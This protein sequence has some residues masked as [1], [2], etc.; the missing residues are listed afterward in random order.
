[1][2]DLAGGLAAGFMLAIIIGLIKFAISGVQ[3]IR[4]RNI[5]NENDIGA[6]K[7]SYYN[8]DLTKEES[9]LLAEKIF[10]HPNGKD[11]LDVA[12]WFASTSFAY[13]IAKEN[14]VRE[15]I[16]TDEDF[17]TSK[18][19]YSRVFQ[20]MNEEQIDKM[21][22]KESGHMVSLF[23]YAYGFLLWVEVDNTIPSSSY[24][25]QYYLDKA[26]GC[27]MVV[28]FTKNEYPKLK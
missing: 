2:D 10:S 22:T 18:H 27:Q 23:Y 19:A 21:D 16:L 28:E 5:M 17:I 4:F 20:N 26:K 14:F 12:L 7:K 3:N 13:V 8:A 1:M 11:A 6:L 25:W 15:Q 9:A 24:S